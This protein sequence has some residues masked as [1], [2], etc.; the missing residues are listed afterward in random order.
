MKKAVLLITILLAVNSS[1]G[2][3][4]KMKLNFFG[5]KFTQNDERL[6][7]KEL[8]EATESNY[9]ANLIIKKA[10]TNRT[11]YTVT[12]FVGGVLIGIPIGQSINDQ[13]PNWTLAYIGGGLALV[14]VPFAF[15]AFNNANEGVD[16]YN[17]SLKSASHFNPE[18]KLF[19]TGN[20]LG[21]SMNF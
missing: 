10:R 13:D 12:Q 4:I 16:K 2:Q 3:E 21:I 14:S 6:S 5:Y 8:V 11:I 20:G 1:F 7:W 18:F 9:E 19:A 17:L 15:A